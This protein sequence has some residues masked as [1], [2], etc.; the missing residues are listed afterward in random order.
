MKI[1]NPIIFWLMVIVTLLNIVDF[2][3]A[4]GGL[5]AE[6][7]PIYLLTGKYFIVLFVKIIMIIIGWILCFDNT[8][9]NEFWLYNYIFLLVIIILLLSVGIYSN[10]TVKQEFKEHP[11]LIE[12]QKQVPTD[13]KLKAYSNLLLFMYFLPYIFC[14]GIFALFLGARKNI[15]FGDTTLKE[16]INKI[17][18]KENKNG[19]N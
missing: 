7:N 4:M 11:E 8:F 13:V 16:L 1:V 10:I 15:K 5:V 18:N 17:K 9:K 2:I 14:V 3:S 12:M 6:T 19:R